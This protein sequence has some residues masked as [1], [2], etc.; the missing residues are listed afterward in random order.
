MYE[1]YHVV[2]VNE[3]DSNSNKLVVTYG[4]TLFFDPL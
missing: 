4:S 3:Q 2:H 1:Y